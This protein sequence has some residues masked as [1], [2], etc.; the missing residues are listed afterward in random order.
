MKTFLVN[1]L[2]DAEAGDGLE[3]LETFQVL[4][5]HEDDAVSKASDAAHAKYPN[6][7]DTNLGWVRPASAMIAPGGDL[8]FII[9]APQ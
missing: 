8:R 3:H 1:I 2:H 7:G 5:E 9:G 4:A 6:L